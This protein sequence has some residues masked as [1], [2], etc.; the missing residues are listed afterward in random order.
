MAIID[1]L[2]AATRGG[3]VD[4]GSYPP[5]T[6]A[7]GQRLNL[8]LLDRHCAAGDGLGGWKLG[9]TSGTSRDAFGPGIRPFGFILASRVFASGVE[10]SRFP[11][12]RLENELC[13]TLAES[14]RGDRV[15]AEDARAAVATVA[16]AYELNQ[17]RLSGPADQ[18]LRVAENLSQWGIVVG[19]GIALNQ[20]DDLEA[21]EVALVLNGREIERVPARG[22]IDDHFA[23]IARLAKEL[24]VHGRGLAPGEHIIT[25]AF[26]RHQA[27]LGHWCGQ[28]GDQLGAVEVNLT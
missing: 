20:V 8:E 17:Q 27:E 19:Q 21:I 28:F 9:L 22:H 11:G 3:Q 14:L 23:S 15:S 13:F 12:M 7:E 10:L 6:L 4:P 26:A 25:G 1:T 2:W 24:A 5:L 18:G 16:P